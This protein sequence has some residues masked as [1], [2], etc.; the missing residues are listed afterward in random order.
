MADVGA[1]GRMR[2]ALRAVALD[3]GL[4]RRRRDFR[5]LTLGQFVSLAGSE[6]TFVALPV[7]C[8]A[9][10]HSTLAVGLLGAAEFVPILLLA[11]VGGALADAF[12]R[13]RL[14]AIAELGALIVS[15]GLVLN[16]LADHPGVWVLFAGAALSAA[17]DALRRPPLDALEPRLVERDELKAAFAIKSA[18]WNL[19]ALGGP[20]GA[21]VLIVSAGYA[22]TYAGDA[23]G[24]VMALGTLAVIRTPPPPAD[25]A[26]PSVRSV[27]EGVRYAASRPELIGTYVVDMCAMFFGMPL[28]VF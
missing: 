7:Q 19:A 6:M 17:C 27:V 11:L 14:I 5:R 12:D 22:A 24:F 15:L 20:A 1:P 16:A 3:A 18:L 4:L 28:A 21:G 26:A 25:A 2:R 8:F 23:A 10:T 9:L 13:R